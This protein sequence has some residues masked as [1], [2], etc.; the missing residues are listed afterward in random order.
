MSLVLE[1]FLGLTDEGARWYDFKEEFPWNEAFAELGPIQRLLWYKAS[2]SSFD[3]DRCDLANA[4]YARL[5]GALPLP[6]RSNRYSPGVFGEIIKQLEKHDKTG[7]AKLEYERDTINSFKTTYNQALAIAIEGASESNPK[8]NPKDYIKYG[9]VDIPKLDREHQQI[10][11][12][13]DSNKEL[14]DFAI[15]THTIGNFTILPNPDKDT[16][17]RGFNVGRN[18]K[19]KDY[20]DLSL[21]L[22]RSALHND[23]L[24]KCYCNE[25]FLTPYYLDNKGNVVQLFN[26]EGNALLPQTESDLNEY[27]RNVNKKILE[28]G[29]QMVASLRKI[30]TPHLSLR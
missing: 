2:R 26:R 20:W 21:E 13:V 16:Y 28:R 19:T 11:E 3:C 17:K 12:K 5:W 25:F 9:W 30:R 29:E 23:E 10:R 24:F 8:L 1:R 6:G 14:Q 27:L 4:I 15:L 22:L 18:A 7:I